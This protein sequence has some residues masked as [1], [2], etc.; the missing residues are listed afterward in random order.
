M[1]N[2]DILNAIFGEKRARKLLLAH[3][4]SA[5]SRIE[6]QLPQHTRPTFSDALTACF[7]YKAYISQYH[8]LTGKDNK[9]GLLTFLFGLYS[10]PVLDEHGITKLNKMFPPLNEVHDRFIEAMD[11]E[12]NALT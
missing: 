11:P 4:Q 3:A 5:P 8:Q 9:D 2:E 12:L 7:Y 6:A 1:E 10:S